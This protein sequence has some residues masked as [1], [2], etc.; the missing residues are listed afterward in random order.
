MR[1]LFLLISCF[2]PLI[3]RSQPTPQSTFAAEF[4][5]TWERAKQYTLEMAE[6]MPDS[7]YHYRPNE[8]LLT[9]AGHLVHIIENWYFLCSKFVKESPYPL[10]DRLDASQLGKAEILTELKRVYAYADTAF[11]GLSDEDLE[12]KAEAFWAKPA[13]SKKVILML[14][15]DHMTHHRGMLAVYLRMQGIKPARYRGW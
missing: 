3:L 6:A 13:V 9:Y 1:V 10:A 2:F 14:M 4:T 15:R 11:Y 5:D 8:E 12:A 7:Q